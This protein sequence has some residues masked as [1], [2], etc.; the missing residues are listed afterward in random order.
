MK[1]SRYAIYVFFILFLF[2]AVAHAQ[3]IRHTSPTQKVPEIARVLIKEKVHIKN[4]SI[5]ARMRTDVSGA[6]GFYQE[7]TN[8]QKKYKNFHWQNIRQ[9]S[10]GRLRLT[11]SKRMAGMDAMETITFFAYP[12]KNGF[13]TYLI[14]VVNGTSWNESKWNII[15]PKINQTLSVLFQ[16]R[17]KIFACATGNLNDKMDIVASNK[18]NNILSQFNAHL[19]ERIV[20]KTFESVSAYTDEWSDSI[21]TNGRKMNL[22]VGLRSGKDGTTVTVGTP[23]ITTEY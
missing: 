23:I 3:N 8:V 2:G 15:S 21:K 6:S 11:G 10:D 5:Y 4:W 12:R 14:Y 19:V 16:Q 20:E 7:A 17:G 18:T 13:Q 22:Q 9:E 1:K